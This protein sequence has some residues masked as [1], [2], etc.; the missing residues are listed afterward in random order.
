MEETLTTEQIMDEMEAMI[1]TAKKQQRTICY[2]VY[3]EDDQAID[4]F[5]DINPYDMD[6]DRD[7]QIIWKHEEAFAYLEKEEWPH[8]TWHGTAQRWYGEYEECA[9]RLVLWKDDDDHVYYEFELNE[10]R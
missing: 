7:V 5:P 10:A 9:D 3:D 2:H 4:G 1:E 8:E 6:V